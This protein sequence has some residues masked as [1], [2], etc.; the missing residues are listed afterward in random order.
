M[1][2][3][4]DAL[5]AKMFM[6]PKEQPVPESGKK[7]SETA[8]PVRGEG[9]PKDDLVPAVIQDPEDPTSEPIPARLSP[10]EFVINADVVRKLGKGNPELGAAI[11]KQFMDNIMTQSEQGIEENQVPNGLA[12]LLGA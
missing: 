2:S 7:L 6:K 1:F 12:S 5:I 3:P 8:E 11:L 4:K 10:G 9:G